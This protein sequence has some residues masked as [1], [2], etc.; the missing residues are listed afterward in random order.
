MVGKVAE[1]GLDWRQALQQKAQEVKFVNQ[2]A[3]EAGVERAELVQ[4]DPNELAAGSRSDPEPAREEEE[5][6]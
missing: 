6:A 4:L 2:L 5:A 1:M 3:A